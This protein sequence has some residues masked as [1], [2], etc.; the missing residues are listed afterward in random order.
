MIDIPD[1]G[2]Y[3]LY[4]GWYLGELTQNDAFFDSFHDSYP[5]RII[6][7]AEYGADANVAYQAAAPERGDYTEGYQCLY[8][9]HLLEMIGQ[10][11][12]LW[13]THAWNMYDFAADGRDEGGKHGVNQKGLVTIDRKIRKDA[14]YLYKAAWSNEP[15]VHLCGKRYQERHE[16]MTQIKVYSNQ[17]S[18]SLYVDNALIGTQRGKRVFTWDVPLCGEHSVKALSG[19][20][21]DSMIIRKVGAPNPAYRLFD[22]QQLENWFDKEAFNTGCYS[23]QD[24]LGD[25]KKHPQAAALLNKIM[26]KARASRG[27]VAS[28]TQGNAALERMMSGMTLQSLLKQA[29]GAVPPEAIKGL[30]SALQQISKG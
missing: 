1:I 11:P 20:L 22:A 7:L 18:V 27:D 15:F 21:R 28:A 25:L 8:H 12:Y 23:I 4:F 9:E 19:E 24:T 5:H 10:R 30:N 16:S 6:G 17:D 14:F 13:A 29:G 2:S 26:A 3:N